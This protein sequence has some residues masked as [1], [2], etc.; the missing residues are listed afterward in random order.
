MDSCLGVEQDLD[1]A[2]SKFSAL[3]DHTNKVLEDVINQV[4]ELRKEIS[5]RKYHM[6]KLQSIYTTN[7]FVMVHDCAYSFMNKLSLNT[8]ENC[9][10][11]V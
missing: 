10:S 6:Y 2:I 4:E 7:V 11:V 8:S 5:N 1:K 3:N 9:F